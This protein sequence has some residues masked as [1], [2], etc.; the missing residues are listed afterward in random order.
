MPIEDKP[1]TQR[2]VVSRRRSTCSARRSPAARWA[3]PATVSATV[4]QEVGKKVRDTRPRVHVGSARRGR[5]RRRDDDRVQAARA[6]RRRSSSRARL[7][8]RSCRCAAQRMPRRS[9]RLS[10][11]DSQMNR[12]LPLMFSSGTEPQHARVVRVRAVVAHHEHVAVGDHVVQLLLAGAARPRVCVSTIV[13]GALVR[14]PAR[15]VGVRGRSSA[16]RSRGLREVLE[17]PSASRRVASSRSRR[18]RSGSW[19][20]S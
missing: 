16:R 3:S 15:A 13:P 8:R 19:K 18:G 14:A 4:K 5:D 12:A 17:S 1:N 7:L 20:V 6:C 11:Y 10:R 2:L 9:S